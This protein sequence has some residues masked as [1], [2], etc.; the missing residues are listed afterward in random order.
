MVKYGQ[1]KN[2]GVL[3]KNARSKC[4]KLIRIP[5][6]STFHQDCTQ[7]LPCGVWSKR[8]K[9]VNIYTPFAAKS[10]AVWRTVVGIASAS[11]RTLLPWIRVCVHRAWS[12]NHNWWVL[13]T[14][15]LST[16]I[17]ITSRLAR[18]SDTL[19][20]TVWNTWNLKKSFNLFLDHRG[21]IRI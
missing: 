14:S 15:R 10:R 4:T 2:L 1:F 17:W 5:F 20:W 8:L 13:C 19:A 12:L 11:C 16:T 21:L 6:S 3:I 7:Q 18:S 9:P